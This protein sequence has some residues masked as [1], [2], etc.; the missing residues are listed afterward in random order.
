[1]AQLELPPPCAVAMPERDYHARPELNAS[2]LKLFRKAACLAK[3]PPHREPTPSMVL[4]SAVHCLVLE[5]EDEFVKR[6]PVAP[7]CNRRT[8]AGKAAW[9]AFLAAQ[10]SLGPGI[11]AITAAQQGTVCRM[12]EQVCLH[13]EARD[14]LDCARIREVSLFGRLD[15]VMCKARLDAVSST[16]LVL[17]LKT[18]ADASPLGFRHSCRT[19]CYWLQ[20]VHYL[21]LANLVWVLDHEFVFIAVETAPPYLV[22]V[23]RLGPRT[24]EHA[25]QE[26]ADLLSRY[27]E[28]QATDVWP[29]IDST[30]PL[31]LYL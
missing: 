9:E 11:T 22:A 18:C 17:D 27:A 13:G 23:T 5:G 28:C 29:G 10:A 6:F 16:G 14:L 25:M 8:K 1:M 3:A 26:H 15:G 20:A 7:E 30:E 24:M 21:R 12:A 4:G 2:R 31:E 19:Y